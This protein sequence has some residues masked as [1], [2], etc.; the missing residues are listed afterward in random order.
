M[1]K[2]PRLFGFL[3]SLVVM[4][5]AM[6]ACLALIGCA[7]LAITYVAQG[8]AGVRTLARLF[9]PARLAPLSSLNAPGQ[10]SAMFALVSILYASA[11][12]GVLSAAWLWGGARDLLGWRGP[13]PQ[14]RASYWPWLLAIPAYHLVTGGVLRLLYPEVSMHMGLPSGALALA[15]SFLALVILAP[16]AEE[17]FFRGWLYGALRAHMPVQKAIFM[18]AMIFALA[19]SDS[20]GLYPVAVFAPGLVLTIIR[21]RTGSTKAAFLAHAIYNFIGW[22]GLAAISLLGF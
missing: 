6:M 22:A 15:L 5:A 12:V 16:L 11:I 18:C 4:A 19:H 1:T 3:L 17:L 20:T 10:A 8:E 2:P 21:E 9:D 13:Y 14:W 7:L